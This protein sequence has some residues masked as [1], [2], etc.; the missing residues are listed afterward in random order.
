MG[1]YEVIKDGVKV[2]RTAGNVELSLKLAEVADDLLE[3]SKKIAELEN[4]VAKL[5]ELKKLNF[6]EGK[7]YLI[8]PDNVNRHFCPVCTLKLKI[9]VPLMKNNGYCNQCTGSFH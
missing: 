6:A 9:Y 5:K 3:K 7:N 8:D 1:F 2:V 4:E